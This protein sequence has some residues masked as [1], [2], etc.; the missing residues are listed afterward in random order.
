MKRIIRLNESDI[1][2]IVKRS[3]NNILREMNE[4]GRFSSFD[5]EMRFV[6]DMYDHEGP[7]DWVSQNDE[8]WDAVINYVRQKW[9]AR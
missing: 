4:T 1:R 2:R 7:A 5:E 8:E 9:G 6:D 3:V